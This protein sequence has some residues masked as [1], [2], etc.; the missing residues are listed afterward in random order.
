[1]FEAVKRD[2]KY[3]IMKRLLIYLTYDRQNIIDGY[4]GYFLRSMR[5]ITDTIVAV[6]N[7]PYIEKGLSNLSDYADHIYY[8][9]NKGLDCG[10]FKDALCEFIGWDPLKECDEL[11]LANDS[12][13]GPFEDIGHIFTEME[14]RHLDFWG[15]M[16]RGSGA[17]GATGKDPEHILSFFYVFQ[18]PMIHS[19]DFRSYWEDMPYYKDY[20]TAV[21]RYERRLTKH[22]ADL[23]YTY[24]AYADTGPNESGNPRNQ[25]FQ[26]DYLSYEMI[27]KRNFPFLKRKQLS[28]NPLFTQTQENLFLSINYVDQHTDYDVSLIWKNLIRVM[29]PAQLQRSLGLQ[30]PLEGGE[31]TEPLEAV[32]IVRVR[33]MNAVDTVCEYLDRMRRVCDIRVYGENERLVDRYLRNGYFAML[34]VKPDIEIIRQTDTEKYRCLCLIHDCDL[35]SEQIPSCTGKSYFFNIWENLLKDTGYVSKIVKLFDTKPYMGMLTHPVPIFSGWIGKL[36]WDWK[37]RYEEVSRYI[38]E[39]KLSGVTDPQTPPVHVTNNFW[40]RA[41]VIKSFVQKIDLYEGKDALPPDIWDYLW[42]YGMQDQGQLTGIVETTFYASMNE[43]NYH[44]YLRTLMGWLSERYGPHEKLHEFR[45]IF[46]A[47][48]AAERCKEKHGG[49]YVYGTGEMAERCFPWLRE[50]LAFIVSDGHRRNRLF[51]GKP[52][53]CLSELKNTRDYG[54]ILCLSKENC[55]HVTELL[56]QRG[57][58]EY[59]PVY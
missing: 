56:E 8:R 49:F 22:F 28:Y 4:I 39:L 52:V 13:Y 21:K 20:M 54:I 48:E 50:A 32:V 27:T 55:D 40:A 11:I 58:K 46:Q 31:E 47:Q 6:C 14:A 24:G 15:L 2:E 9:E 19:P 3:H 1:V 59:Y 5:S 25:F 51:H 44:Y 57:I 29:N 38:R 7:M 16:K 26:C 43:V 18:A 10:G 41:D 37:N 36:E 12:F 23:G 17:Y 35:S 45:E 33:W 30:Y 34:S 42:T 53:I